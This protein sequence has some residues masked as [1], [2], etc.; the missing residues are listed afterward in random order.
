M[1]LMPNKYVNFVEDEHFEKCVKH[2][3]TKFEEIAHQTGDE[4]LQ[5]HGIDPIKMMFDMI[6]H[7]LTFEEWKIKEKERQDDKSVN[8]TIGE[9]HQMLLGGVPGWTDLGI[10]DESHLDLKKDDDTIFLEL[11]NKE[12]TVNSDSKKQVRKKL[13]D[14]ASEF[15]EAKCYWA[16]IVAENGRSEDKDWKYKHAEND[17]DSIRRLTGAKIYELITGDGE[18]LK[19][20]WKKLPLAIKEVYDSDFQISSADNQIFEK[21]FEDAFHKPKKPRKKKS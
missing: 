10:G 6:Q 11:K 8:N 7:K 9:F 12:N 2:V 3:C 20:V 13:E 5:K 14:A 15:N 18:N 4:E 19:K 1:R 21:W 16:Y 17:S